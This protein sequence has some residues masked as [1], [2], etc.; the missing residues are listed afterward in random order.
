[1]T[2]DIK[3]GLIL[4]LLDILV[5]ICVIFLVVD[6]RKKL[7]ALGEQ[8][9]QSFIIADRLRQSSDELTRMVRTY[10]ATGDQKFKDQFL[11]V[12][13]I[14][15]GKAG[16]PI[17]YERI[18]WDF[19]AVEGGEAPFQDAPAISLIQLMEDCGFNESELALLRESKARSDK[20]I[21]LELEA[22]SLIENVDD[23]E[24]LEDG[25]KKALNLLFGEAY[26]AAK[27]DI[28]TPINQFLEQL[29]HRTHNAVAKQEHRADLLFTSLVILFFFGISLNIW[30][31]F[32]RKKYDALHM[33]ELKATIKR[34]TEELKALVATKEHILSI[35]SHDLRGPLGSVKYLTADLLEN[36]ETTPRE[37]AKRTLKI[38]DESIYSTH[39]LMEN[40]L[41]WAKLHQQE[42]ACRRETLQLSEIIPSAILAQL[43]M[44][45]N[46]EINVTIEI[47]PQNRIVA[48]TEG[49]SLILRNLLSNAVKFTHRG[50]EISIKSKTTEQN[51]ILSVKD[52]G[53]GIP[54]QH[55]HNIFE[56]GRT[57]RTLGTEN[58]SSSG[59]GLN[60]AAEFTRTFLG[61]LSVES[62]EGVGTSFYL[63][64]PRPNTSEQRPQV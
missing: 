41:M 15:Q 59:F 49:L 60:I 28:M 18:Y 3:L 20:L 16:R 36:F 39:E 14:R 51:V 26:H 6:A 2:R 42:D 46:K 31:L 10:V 19:L 8:R 63:S 7:A 1:M 47:D 40:M 32:L 44:A 30:L 53:I 61:D 9:H 55:I 57:Y 13:E 54:K 64:I 12:M 24:L 35:V 45:R 37:E 52:N 21:K 58:E 33:V 4:L 5:A 22:M 25:R 29:D 34:R 50:G 48:E 56:N 38:I 11:R 62:E 17:A 27:I 23:P 43:A